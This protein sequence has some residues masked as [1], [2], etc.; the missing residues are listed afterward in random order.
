MTCPYLWVGL[1]VVGLFATIGSL[2]ICLDSG[3][4]TGTSKESRV[5]GDEILAN[6]GVVAGGDYVV[7]LVSYSSGAGTIWVKQAHEGLPFFD[8]EAAFHFDARGRLQRD[9]KGKPWLVGGR[10][11]PPVSMDQPNLGWTK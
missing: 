11:T 7:R 8:S 6:N 10:L 1:L 2:A 9:A 3:H 5:R 4:R